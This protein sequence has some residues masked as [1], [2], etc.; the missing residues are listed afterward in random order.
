MD[1]C[2]KA[3][4]AALKNT[5]VPKVEVVA[6][7]DDAVVGDNDEIRVDPE[8]RSALNLSS[9]GDPVSCTIAVFEQ[10]LF[11][12]ESSCLIPKLQNVF[13]QDKLLVDPTEDEE[14]LASGGVITVVLQ[15]P[16]SDVTDQQ[17]E[18]CHVHKPAGASV[19]RET[20]QKCCSLAKKQ[21]KQIKKLI[22]TASSVPPSS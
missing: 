2:L 14:L 19:S 9:R 22:D 18:I 5:T 12:F 6:K 13:Q 1:V 20:L 21:C 11:L 3:A 16:P 8:D 4:V 15:I 10:V 17:P 7:D